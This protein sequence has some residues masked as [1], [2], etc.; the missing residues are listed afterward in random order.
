MDIK[1]MDPEK[2]KLFTGQTN[3]LILQ[4]AK[5]LG[6]HH[7]NVIIR[8][9]VVPGVN[10][11]PDEIDAIAKFANS[12]GKGIK[13][14]HLLP[15]H[16]LGEDKYRRLGRPYFLAGIEPIGKEKMEELLRVASRY[17]LPVQIGG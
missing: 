3:D 13:S 15:Y 7:P 11:E 6:Q 17:E 4:N 14:I 8:V 1:H 16:R 9:P 10:D 5:Y 12:L 2:H